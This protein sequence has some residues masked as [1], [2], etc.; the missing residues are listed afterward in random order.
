MNLSN[1]S[2]P[3]ISDLFSPLKNVIRRKFL[4]SL[5]GQNAFNDITRELMALPVRL[6]GLG[7]TNPCANTPLHHDASLKITAPLT[8]LIMEQ[9]N[10]YPNTT[11]IEQIRFK[12]EAV[13]ARK[14]RQQQAAAE[15]KDKLPNSMQRAMSLSTV[16]GSSICSRSTLPIA[17]YGYALHKSAFHDA[18]CLRYGWHPSNLPLQCTCGKQFS[19]EHALS[20]SHGGFPSIRHNELRD[21]SAVCHNVGTEPPLQPIT[22]EQLI[23]QTANRKDG[24]RLDLAVIFFSI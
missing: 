11:K 9:S 13:K 24:A 22:D 10:Q 18:L 7:I 14:H 23:H 2:H 15:L 4:I 8:A 6:G 12:K 16:K 19:V 21:M 20:C 17:E 5:T 3:Q 1:K